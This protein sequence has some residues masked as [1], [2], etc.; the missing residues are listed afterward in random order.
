MASA[1]FKGGVVFARNN[2]SVSPNAYDTIEENANLSGLGVTNSLI[3]VTSHD[4]AAREYIAGL[5][6]GSEITLECNYIQTASNKQLDLMSDIDNQLTS[7]FRLTMTD[8]SV[9]PNT[10]KTFTFN[11][12]CQ[13]WDIGPSFD[14][15]HMISFTLKI[16]GAITRA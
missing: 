4:S 12:V 3:E 11:A 15:K 2:I 16:S 6:D 14:D 10:I 13:S 1:A 9:S 8:V 7:G 5:A